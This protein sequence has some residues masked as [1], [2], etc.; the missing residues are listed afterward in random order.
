MNLLKNTKPNERE[1]ER[2]D[3]MFWKSSI[4]VRAGKNPEVFGL[5]IF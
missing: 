5:A 3:R 2:V 1:R 4:K